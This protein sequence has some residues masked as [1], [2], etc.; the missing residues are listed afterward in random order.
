MRISKRMPCKCRQN[1]AIVVDGH[2][3]YWYIQMLK[4]NERAINVNLEP[5]IPQK[6]KISDQY[7]KV[8]ELAEEFSMV[9][10]IIDLDVILKESR[11]TQR[12]R[13]KPIDDLR[14]YIQSIERRETITIIIN[15]PCLEYWFLLHFQFNTRHFD[16]C[17]S[18]LRQLKRHND[19]SNY[20][21]TKTFYTKKNN[22]IYLKL[23]PYLETAVA[24]ANRL[25]PFN[26]ENPFA[27]LSQ[28]QLLFESNE[29]E[30]IIN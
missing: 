28:M 1:Y 4:R 16:S 22:D 11:E 13:R 5:K 12:G 3:E 27:A 7:N 2:C 18:V 17:Q 24:N 10:W 25:N 23:K 30:Q 26:I 21:K 6:K 8:I 19:L 29:L 9:F 20:D 14:D 15:N